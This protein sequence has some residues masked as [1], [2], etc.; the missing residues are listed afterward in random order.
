MLTNVLQMLEHSVERYPDKI[1]LADTEKAYTYREYADK[2]RRLG[3]VIAREVGETRRPIAVSISREARHIIEF[4]GVVYSG[5]FYVPLDFTQ[6]QERVAKILD[7]TQPCMIIASAEDAEQYAETVDRYPHLDPNAAYDEAA[8]EAVLEAVRAQTLDTDPLYAIFTSGSTGTPKGIVVGHHSVLD[9]VHQ[10][11]RE[12]AFADDSVF[13]NQ[14]PFDF[15]VSV[16]DI[17]N[18][19]LCGGTIRVIPQQYF[20]MPM[21]LVEYL[22]ENKI[23]TLIWATS[24]LRIMENFRVLDEAKPEHLRWLMFSGEIMPNKVINY[25]RANLPDIE[26]VNLYGPT[27]ITCN[28]TFYHVDR[29]FED[30]D[31]LPIGIP[32]RNTGILLL[33]DEDKPIEAAGQVGEICVLGSSLALGYYNNPE[34]TAAAFCQNPLNTAYPERMYRTGDL[35]EYNDRGE[36]LFRSRKDYQIKHMGHRIELGEIE[37]AVNAL[38][39]IKASF[40]HYDLEGERIHLFYV[41][42]EECRRRIMKDLREFLPKY[43]VPNKYHLWEEFPLNKNNKIDRKRIIAETL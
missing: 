25:W 12:F 15:D 22:N 33:D 31:S 27:E 3:T 30:R 37:Q 13:G 6:P 17:Y 19:M 21:M 42:D 29:P 35:A 28:C 32:F 34:Q 39:Y 41:A 2:A 24:A 20:S 8:D 14:A 18:A 7:T 9:L 16:K 26:Y 5:N 43:M 23:N 38:P 36:L 10:F 1:A 40:C 11:K 4:M